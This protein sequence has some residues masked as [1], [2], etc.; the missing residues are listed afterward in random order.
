MIKVISPIKDHRMQ[1]YLL[2]DVMSLSLQND[3]R[4][5]MDYLFDSNTKIIISEISFS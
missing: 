1:I 3:F 2:F 5:T 4:F